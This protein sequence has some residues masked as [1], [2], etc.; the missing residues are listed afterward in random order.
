MTAID[1]PPRMP[2]LRPA[3]VGP[4]L[5]A[6][7]VILTLLAPWLPA[8]LVAW[9]EAWVWPLAAWFNASFDFVKDDLGL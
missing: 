9:P 8:A 7:A 6:V 3:L 1:M 2:A 4:V 5:L